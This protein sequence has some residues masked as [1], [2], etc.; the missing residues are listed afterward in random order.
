MPLLYSPQQNI[1]KEEEEKPLI[2]EE[3]EEEEEFGIVCSDPDAEIIRN[4]CCECLQE[5]LFVFEIKNCICKYKFVL[6][7][8]CMRKMSNNTSECPCHLLVKSWAHITQ[9]ETNDLAGSTNSRNYFKNF[10]YNYNQLNK[11]Q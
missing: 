6:G 9:D 10:E 1:F 7:N 11:F 5:N 4:E 2:S 8:G 3:E